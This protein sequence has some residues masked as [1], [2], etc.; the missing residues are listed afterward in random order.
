MAKENYYP[1]EVANAVKAG[2]E[3]KI[4]DILKDQA[5]R[6]LIEFFKRTHKTD[7]TLCY[8]V[9]KRIR[10]IRLLTPRFFN[11]LAKV[12]LEEDAFACWPLCI[13]A[14]EKI[15]YFW[16][17]S[18]AFTVE[19]P[20]LCVL[21][22]CIICKYSTSEEMRLFWYSSW[23]EIIRKEEPNVK[24]DRFL[25]MMLSTTGVE[26]K[27]WNQYLPKIIRNYPM[28]TVEYLSMWPLF[29]ATK[30]WDKLARRRQVCFQMLD[31]LIS[32]LSKLREDSNERVKKLFFY[33]LKEGKSLDG[34]W[35]EAYAEFEQ[36][37]D[38][39]QKSREA[40][41]N[42]IFKNLWFLDDAFDSHVLKFGE[43]EK[44]LLGSDFFIR[45][46]AVIPW[47]GTSDRFNLV[48]WGLN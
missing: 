40:V 48:C 41:F 43:D 47:Q 28:F 31:F 22:K 5:P 46:G 27:F 45:G 6:F 12:V 14:D 3:E 36:K 9:L 7:S 2:N 11:N 26:C 20:L 10:D 33:L 38:I 16:P 13:D 23:I 39:L 17:E 4:F 18:R 21:Y 37:S 24:N 29:D 19:E 30:V 42:I 35:S 15:Q 44:A 34:T 25:T 1:P 32:E 8:T